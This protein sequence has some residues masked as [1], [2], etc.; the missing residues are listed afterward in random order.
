MLGDF[1]E[2]NGMAS[3]NLV[4]E[5]IIVNKYTCPDL[6]LGNGPTQSI[7]SFSNGSFSKGTGFKCAGDTT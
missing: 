2:R 1:K 7:T 6:V 5:H 3:G 4:A